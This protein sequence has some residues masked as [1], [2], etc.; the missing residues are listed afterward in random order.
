[1]YVLYV[2]QRKCDSQNA[3]IF[4]I[5]LKLNTITEIRLKKL[6]HIL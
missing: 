6:V 5:I 1:M 4:Q 2:I 3:S